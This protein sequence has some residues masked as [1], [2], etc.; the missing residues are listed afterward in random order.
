MPIA[1]EPSVMSS[2][3]SMVAGHNAYKE[4]AA[5]NKNILQQMLSDGG[6]TSVVPSVTS[7]SGSYPTKA[8]TASAK[9]PKG[10]SAK[11]LRHLEG[12]GFK[13]EG[14][15]K[16]YAVAMRESGGRPSA[17]NGNSATGDK[18]YGLFQI[19]MIGN[20]GK[21]RMKQLGLSS[22]EDLLDP[23]INARAAYQMTKG[24]KRWSA[25][26]I[27]ETGYNYKTNR[28][29]WQKHYDAYMKFYNAYPGSTKSSRQSAAARSI[30]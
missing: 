8:P 21:A 27:D 3:A 12:A 29:S 10:K 24:G 6:G 9:V 5:K 28:A 7:A 19:N 13:G 16:A 23:T 25:W 15:R 2:A 1:P 17:Y 11:L 22:Y 26:D 30:S 20:L 4:R 14:L 18:S